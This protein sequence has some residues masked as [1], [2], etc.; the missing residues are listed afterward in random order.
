MLEIP[1]TGIRIEI[2]HAYG[3][4]LT[5]RSK[6]ELK[7][8]TEVTSSWWGDDYEVAD[9]QLLFHLGPKDR[10]WRPKVC[11]DIDLRYE[12]LHRYIL[13]LG[14]WQVAAWTF[15]ALKFVHATPK[16]VDFNLRKTFRNINDERSWNDS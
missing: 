14:Y 2:H 9:I 6:P 16:E 7:V 8:C 3:D 11:L 10:M 13:K 5:I 4:Y 1:D 15:S 12:K